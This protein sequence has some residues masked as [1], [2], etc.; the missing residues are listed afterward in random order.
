M[1]EWISVEDKLPEAGVNVLVYRPLADLTGDEAVKI[2]FVLR[3]GFYTVSPQN[4][5]HRFSCWCHPTHWA[6]I[7]LPEQK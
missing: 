4:V 5:N 7:N 6:Y 1:V 2:S 3:E